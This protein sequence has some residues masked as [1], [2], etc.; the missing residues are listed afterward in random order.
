MVMTRSILR[1][2]IGLGKADETLKAT[3]ALLYRDIRRGMFVSM[4]YIVLDTQKRLINCA[5]AGHNPLLLAHTDGIVEMYHPSGI[6]LG[7]DAGERFNQKLQAL[8]ITLQSGDALMI[9]TDG[10]SEAMNSKHQEFTEERIAEI[11]GKN[12]HKNSEDITKILVQELQ[13]FTD[14]TIQHDDM[15]MVL[16]KVA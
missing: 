13:K 10:V 14:G 15:T 1:S 16:I 12:V 5:N 4:F 9:Y 8:D 2:K 11:L 3:N 7:L 6:A